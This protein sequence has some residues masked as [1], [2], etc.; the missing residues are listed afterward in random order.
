MAYLRYPHIQGQT[1]AFTAADDVWLAPAEG[2]RAWR[3]TSDRAPVKH[4]RISPDQQTVAFISTRDGHPEVYAATIGTGAITRLTYW[5]GQY[6]ALLGWAPDGRL[7]AATNAGEFTRRNHV[8]RALALDGQWE[9]LDYG[10]ASGLAISERGTVALTTPYSRPPAHWK[11]YRGGTAPKLWLH[12]GGKRSGKSQWSQPLAE[13]TAGM[14]DP[15]WI[16]DSLVFTSD[17]AATFPKNT[18]EQANLWVLENATK[19]KKKN[20]T[21]TQLT[22]Q[23]EQTGY[24]R[25][26]TSDGERIIWH[27]RGELYLLDSL[28]ASPRRLELTLPGSAAAEQHPS[29]T[30]AL[31]ALVPDHGADASLVSWR[32][33]TYWL[34]HR[35]GPARALEARSGVRTRDPLPL[36]KTGKAVLVTDAAG[37]D[38]LE[39]HTLDGSA[40]PQRILTGELGRVLSLAADPVGERLA[41][42]THE[43][44]I[45]LISLNEKKTGLQ[46]EVTEVSRSS[47]GESA[48]PSFSPDGRYLLFSRPTS[49]E[50]QLHQ[51]VLIDTRAKQPTAVPVTSGQFNDRSPAFTFDGKYVVFLSDRTFDPQYDAHEFALSFAGATRPWLLPISAA[52]PAPF[53]PSPQ[54][55]QISSPPAGPGSKTDAKDT[56]QTPPASPDLDADAEQRLVPFP[57]PSAEY[58][59][60]RTAANG[61]LWIAKSTETG[62]LGTRRAGVPGEQSPDQLIRWD[63]TTR[64]AEPI[65]EKLNSYAV[66]GDGQRLVI[67]EGENVTVVPADR[68]VENDDDARIT[69]DLSRLRRSLDWQAEALQMF[70]ETCRLMTQQFWREDMDG[71]DWAGVIERWRPVVEKTRTQDDLVDLLWETVG[72]LN[73]SHA[74]VIPD[75]KKAPGARRRLGFLGA[76]FTPDEQGVRIERILPGESTEPQARSP[77][78]APG[79]NAAAG[80]VITAVDG[81]PAD[82]KTGPGAQLVGAAEKPV[83]LT[84]LRGEGKEQSSRR[85]VVVPL[86]SEA[87]LRYQDWVR[88]RR[89]YVA[90]KSGGRLGYLHVPDMVSTGWAQLHRDLRLASRAEGIIADVR[91]NS[92]G[93]TSQ[94]VISRLAQRVVAWARARHE[95]T[96]DSYPSQASRG[97]VVLVAN[98]HSGSD[99]DIVNGIAQALEIGPVV[100]VRTWGGV[101]GIDGRFDLVDGTVVTQPKYSYWMEGKGW[102]VE[103]HGI[104]PDIEVIHDPGQLFAADDPQLDRAIEEAFSHLAET[105]AATPP[106]LPEPKMR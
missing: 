65:V 105:P 83:E 25:D 49:G 74:Y 76:E 93:H 70:D 62:E 27:S 54:G 80:D 4:P 102:G 95:E 14:V 56:D 36:G 48:H 101:V 18:T 19:G 6:T 41:A 46:P 106:Q 86:S 82:P 71:V 98:E 79:V 2:G 24:V 11:R 84:L 38:S 39:I 94:L 57:V 59:E 10:S 66:S 13:E 50:S 9:R 103:N 17:R 100:G 75:D 8:V 53:G 5:G 96:Y 21:P 23:D 31:R 68:K 45:L 72:E 7:L 37:E 64:K 1:I 15:L 81:I 90:E 67:L 32:G 51:L 55:W 40:D 43:G 63:F 47:H 26:A 88:S 69:V 87:E 30:D 3:L 85:V 20:L 92:G 91:F 22:F 16:G 12:P 99:G 104:D 52:D 58:A 78:H 97:P 60:L 35:E 33:A 42:I 61:V 77:L 44:R 34:A 89:E 73:T 29:P 28:K